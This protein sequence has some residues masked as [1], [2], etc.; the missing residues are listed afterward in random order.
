MIVSVII[1]LLEWESVMSGEMSVLW[2]CE[3]VRGEMECV[4]DYVIGWL[5]DNVCV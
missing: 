4:R 1:E 5:S 3:D 2:R